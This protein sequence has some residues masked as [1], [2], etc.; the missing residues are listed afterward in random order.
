[1][2]AVSI[3]Q[4][5]RIASLC[6][7]AFP[8]PLQEELEQVGGEGP[9]AEKIGMQWC[10]QQIDDLWTAGAPGLHLYI[11]NRA[12]IV[13]EPVFIKFLTRLSK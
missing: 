9:E 11:L 13:E 12:R 7:C 2:P 4:V 6:G 10:L 3:K 1:M 8:R 5:N